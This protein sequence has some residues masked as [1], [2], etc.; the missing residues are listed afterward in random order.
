MAIS[1]RDGQ[2]FG[3][4]RITESKSGVSWSVGFGDHLRVTRHPGGRWTRSVN[5][6]GWRKTT[7]L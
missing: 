3:P 1:F 2:K 5:M 6:F 4:F 7:R